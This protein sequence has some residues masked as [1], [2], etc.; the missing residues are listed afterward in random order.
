MANDDLNLGSGD[1]QAGEVEAK[2]KSKKGLIIGLVVL[3]LLLAGGGAAF[4]LMGGDDAAEGEGAEAAA[5]EEVIEEEPDPIYYELA[6]AFVVNF[7]HKGRTRYLQ[8]ELQVMSFKQEVIDK[9]Q[10]NM[11]AVRNDLL[12]LISQQDF[13]GLAT[14]EG[15]ESLRMQVLEAI[16]KASRL[17]GNQQ[18]EDVYFTGFVMQ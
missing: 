18:V 17:K 6:P 14:I 9:V 7:E 8:I 12:L 5:Q 4:F 11:P 13:D 1:A 2:G 10:A 3:V 16:N 15:K